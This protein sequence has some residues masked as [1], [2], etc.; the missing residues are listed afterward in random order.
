MVASKTLDENA[1]ICVWFIEMQNKI[2][3]KALVK[4]YTFITCV[5]R[6]KQLHIIVSQ[7]K[8]CFPFS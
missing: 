3:N 2:A 4:N 8:T 5:F 7:M 6:K 1:D